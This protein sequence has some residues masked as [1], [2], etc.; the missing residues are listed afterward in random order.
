[1]YVDLQQFCFHYLPLFSTLMEIPQGNTIKIAEDR[2]LKAGSSPLPSRGG[3]LAES[4]L[5]NNHAV[6]VHPDPASRT[7]SGSKNRVSGAT[8][9]MLSTLTRV[10]DGLDSPSAYL[11]SAD[12]NH[13]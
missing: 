11:W 4:A 7:P 12:R 2:T 10:S 5:R 9:G 3:N 6:Q 8:T 1:M 13:S